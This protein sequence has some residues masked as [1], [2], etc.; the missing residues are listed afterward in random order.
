MLRRIIKAD[1]LSDYVIELIGTINK[2]PT[3]LFKQRGETKVLGRF[4]PDVSR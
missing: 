4:T 1:Q 3:V 2:F